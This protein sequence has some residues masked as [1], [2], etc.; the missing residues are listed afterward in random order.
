MNNPSQP[1]PPAGPSPR[2]ALAARV[3]R[4]NLRPI[5]LIL[6]LLSGIWTLV[7]SIGL[8]KEIN[9]DRT[10]HVPK[11]ANFAIALGA[12][13]M[14][15]AVIEFFGVAAAGLQNLRLIRTYAILSLVSAVLVIGAAFV[16]VIT[17]FVLKNDLLSECQDLL[18]NHTVDFRWGIWGPH[19]SRQLQPDEAA[20]WCK[21]AWNHDSASE[22]ISLLIEIVAMGLFAAIA[23]AYYRQTL[24]PTS[25]ANAARA[26]QS[27]GVAG[28]YNPAYNGSN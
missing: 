1:P 11:L 17:H 25:A 9:T 4:S 12:I 8:F 10:E 28:T 13:Y 26:P 3:Y 21:D 5:V 20:S 27:T 18:T 2:Y 19:E 22:I 6:A 15:A 7:W 16:R 14:A 24:D 23:W